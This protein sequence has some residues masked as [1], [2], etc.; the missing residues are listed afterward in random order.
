MGS[1]H[2]GR[3]CYGPITEIPGDIC[4]VK[5]INMRN[6]WP[7]EGQSINHEL[8]PLHEKI[9]NSTNF[10]SPQMDS[11]LKVFREQIEYVHESLS[12]LEERITSLESED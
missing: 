7:P 6:S 3:S 2:R 11:I 8:E 4:P 9:H 1:A 10:P 5:I 12:I